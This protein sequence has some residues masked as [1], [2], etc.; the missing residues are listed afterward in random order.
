MPFQGFER[1]WAV[2]FWTGKG[3]MAAVGIYA[4]A[5]YFKYNAHVRIPIEFGICE[6]L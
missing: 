4:T 1:A 3:I 2:R 6:G 5:Y